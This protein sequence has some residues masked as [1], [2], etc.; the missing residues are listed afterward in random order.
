MGWDDIEYAVVSSPALSTVRVPRHRIGALG[1]DAL[2][3]PG[4]AV[5]QQRLETRFVPRDSTA[6]RGGGA[7]DRQDAGADG[8]GS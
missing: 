4:G 5:T 2:V 8:S 1:I 3:A 7:A 6:R